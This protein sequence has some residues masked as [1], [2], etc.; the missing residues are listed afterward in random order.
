VSPPFVQAVVPLF[1]FWLPCCLSACP[2]CCPLSSSY[3][4]T[5]TSE[6]FCQVTT[7]SIPETVIFIFIAVR[8]WNLICVS[9]SYVMVRCT[10]MFYTALGHEMFFNARQ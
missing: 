7:R 6:N 4:T 2:H 1:S 3:N 9:V 5:E 10:V 8:T